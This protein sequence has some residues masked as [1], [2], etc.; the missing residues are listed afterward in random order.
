[1]TV[2]DA[3][4]WEGGKASFTVTY[5][6]SGSSGAVTFVAA[7]NEGAVAAATSGTD[8]TA[9][10]SLTSYTFPGTVAGGTNA[11][12]VTV[13]SLVDGDATASETFRLIAATS[14]QNASTGSGTIF[15]SPS[16][17]EIVLSGAT[18]VPETA[19]GG[20]QKSV[21]ITATSTNP[22]PY[23]VVIPVKTTSG[24]AISTG[25]ANRDYTALSSTATIVIPADQT[26]GTTT[27][28]LWDDT[29][30][31]VDTQTFT[32][33]EDASR[34]TL[35]GDV[36][37][38]QSSVEI[39]IK[40]DDAV[41]TIS[42]GDAATAKEGGRLT[43]P[44]TL[45]NPSELGVE[46]QLT[47]VGVA[48]SSAAAATVATDITWVNGPD[49]VAVPA[50]AKTTNVMIPVPV[51]PVPAVGP[52]VV[53]G[54]E[55]PENVRV[56]L[57]DPDNATL[58]TPSTANGLI[59]DD[60]DGQAVLWSTVNDGPFN[61]STFAEGDDG[62]TDK[63][64]FVKFDDGDL[65]TT[66]NYT[67]V[68]VTA[69]NGTDYVGTAGSITVPAAGAA[70]VSIPV[71]I[72]ADRI[73]EPHET[74]KLVVTDP[75][76]VANATDIGEV[77]FTI[78]DD[79]DPPTWTTEDVAVQEGNSGT[80]LARIPVKL[81]GPAM[82]D[83][84]FV[85]GFNDGSAV[86]AASTTGSNDYNQLSTT[87][88]IKAGETV[89]YLDVPVNGDEVYE[90]E[91][92]FTVDFTPPAEVD[93]SSPDTVSTARVTIG[94]DDATPKLT[95]GQFSG[96]EGGTVDVTGTVV[97]AS[98]YE[99]KIGFAAAGSGDNPATSGGVDFTSPT[100][101]A[102]PITIPAGFT[103][104][105]TDAPVSF[106]PLAFAL[107][108]DNIDE[109]TETFTFTASEATSSL[110]GFATSTAAVK[111]ADDTLDL[112]PSASI[113]DVSI[114]ENEQSVD[115][116]VNLTFTSD[117]DATSTTQTV[118]IPYYTV[119]GSAV[120]PADYT[121]TKGTL[122]IPGGTLSKTINVPIKSD[123]LTEANENFFVK[124]GTPGPAGATVGKASGEAIIKANTGTTVPDDD[125]PTLKSLASFRLG[126]GNASLSGKAAAGATVE[127]WG[128][129]ADSDEG[130][131][132]KI[133]QTTASSSGAF[134]FNPAM[135]T[136]GM[137]FMAKANDLSS[138]AVKVSIR[139]DPDIAATS[140]GRRTVKLT[141][142][143]DPKI[144][145][146]E[147]RVFRVNAG[148]R[149]TLVG[150]GRLTATGT[151]TK[152]L[153]GLASGRSYTYKAYIVGIGSRGILTGYSSYTRTVRVR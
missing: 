121:E 31:E 128:R 68:D 26:V 29:S 50:Y 88:T 52:P 92:S 119:D 27:V 64:I 36:F 46:A 7:N 123:N 14:G 90:R 80:A 62:T 54:F 129:N 49:N 79:D 43:F 20:V 58:G 75:S 66:L 95:F 113:E 96:P 147:A 47:A 10:P 108:N 28:Q 105:L 120:E 37:N 35:G 140:T 126:A 82:A 17:N 72:K 153:T 42:V 51:H 112:P 59:T 65:P 12:T 16:T 139:E 94:N 91:E 25:G 142:T 5:G 63:K 69:K 78:T 114:G 39:G 30:D 152:T 40:D 56:T 34:T 24:T 44:L 125:A 93:N 3:T 98:Q 135:T 151:F 18:T 15:E 11:V 73:D 103:G 13:Q 45:S 60:E 76:G 149:L 127:L 106:V 2:T 104:L 146:L 97:G 124:L 102:T 6:G 122:T 134:A 137:Y 132:A 85:A 23:D 111:I 110:K 141:V 71:V 61:T 41:P 100:A 8:F 87:V 117:N 1:M 109:A 67:F 53:T 101:L 81:S 55:G 84:I 9:T 74:F 131:Y 118:S 144:R 70:A 86:D 145:G 116:A 138:A 143:G 4:T 148:G 115:I 136:H 150:S 22:Q 107:K 21:T 19:T 57:S 48:T 83:A 99:Y 133:T 38:A 32:V 89:G 33:E 77:P 130:D